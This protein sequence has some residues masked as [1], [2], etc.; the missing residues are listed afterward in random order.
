[1]SLDSVDYLDLCADRPDPWEQLSDGTRPTGTRVLTIP[2]LSHTA[3]GP[4][5][6]YIPRSGFGQADSPVGSAVM[7]TYPGT[8]GAAIQDI[9]HQPRYYSLPTIRKPA[10]TVKGEFDRLT[11]RRSLMLSYGR[12]TPAGDWDYRLQRK[13]ILVSYVQS[14]NQ[15]LRKTGGQLQIH[16]FVSPWPWWVG[17]SATTPSAQGATVPAST[18]TPV[19]LPA[20]S[21]GP[22]L[23]AIQWAY[24]T[25]SS[26]TDYTLT[27]YRGSTTAQDGQI[28][29]RNR[30]TGTATAPKPPAGTTSIFLVPHRNF[31][32]AESIGG[33]GQG[34]DVAR[35]NI[36]GRGVRGDLAPDENYW[37][38]SNRPCRIWCWPSHRST[39]A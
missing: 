12:D 10:D 16:D 34:T 18:T 11:A 14:S 32:S 29:W 2:V 36:Y 24:T 1:M 7:E 37:I 22:I 31:F 25:V 33:A 26:T 5:T 21:E 15:Q 35:G 6:L 8:S 30:G 28:T 17:G 13:L 4:A 20:A 3:T 9:D 38:A 39:G 19:L 23:W 27:L